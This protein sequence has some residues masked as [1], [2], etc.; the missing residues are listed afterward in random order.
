M[1]R[2]IS[3][4]DFKQVHLWRG[5]ALTWDII[6]K[7]MGYSD[8]SGVRKRYYRDLKKYQPPEHGSNAEPIAYNPSYTQQKINLPDYG[9]VSPTHYISN[10]SNDDWIEHYTGFNWKGDYLT[11]MRNEIWNNQKLLLLTFRF[12]GK[13]Y[14]DVL[15]IS[16][17]D[18]RSS[19]THSMFW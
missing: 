9:E 15:F 12:G 4:Y 3:H 18:S 5:V 19:R 10:L 16:Q 11:E 13:N 17:M 1:S 14:N 6:A 8:Q 2:N 7:R